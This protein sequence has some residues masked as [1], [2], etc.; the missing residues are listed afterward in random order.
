[1]V[2]ERFCILT[3]MISVCGCDPG[4]R[5][6]KICGKEVVSDKDVSLGETR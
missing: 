5:S 4:Q 1:M 3:A 6:Y 2:L